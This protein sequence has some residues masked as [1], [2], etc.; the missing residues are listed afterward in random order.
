[1]EVSKSERSRCLQRAGQVSK[2]FQACLLRPGREK[3]SPKA[4]GEE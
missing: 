1:M 3:L 2:L 4:K